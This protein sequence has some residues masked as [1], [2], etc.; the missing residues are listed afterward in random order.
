[1]HKLPLNP[2]LDVVLF[3]VW[4]IEFMGPFVNSFGNKYIFMAVDYV[5][6]WV[7]AIALSII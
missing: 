3:D 1:M 4:G 7:E 5:S 2:I 6:M